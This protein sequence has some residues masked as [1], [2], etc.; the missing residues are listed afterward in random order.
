MSKSKMN[1]AYC[2]RKCSLE[3]DFCIP[4]DN[5]YVCKSCYEW[6]SKVSDL[7]TKLAEKERQVHVFAYEIAFLDNK[8]A[9]KEREL[10]NSFWKQ[11]CDSLQKA[12]AD[13]DKEIKKLKEVVDC[14]D[15]LKQF[16]ADMKDYALVNR[17][18]ADEIY[19][20]HQAK[21]DF[22]IEQLKQTKKLIEEK[23][24]YDVEESDWAV[25]YE[26]DI[27]EIFDQQIKELKEN[28]N[29]QN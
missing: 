23:Y 1:C 18:V 21:T 22:A 24:T 9:E 3:K 26:L 14:V 29:G 2:G 5:I 8:L 16:N 20:E 27:D 28:P 4:Q 6:Q 13:K 11:E 17:A 19:C 12:L 25:V 15:K 7:E 10:D